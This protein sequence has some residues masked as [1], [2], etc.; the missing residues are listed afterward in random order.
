MTFTQMF[1]GSKLNIV[2]FI[3]FHIF[4]NLSEIFMKFSANVMLY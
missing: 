2:V 4:L 1:A 3:N